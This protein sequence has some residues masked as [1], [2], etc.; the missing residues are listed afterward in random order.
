MMPF[1][2]REG[3]FW[4]KLINPTRMPEGEDWASVDWEVVEVIDNNG[5]GEEKFAVAFT[6]IAPWQWPRDCV[7]GAE[8]VRPA[9]LRS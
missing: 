6:G 1:P 7:F 4:A 5:E 8:V 9:C 2:A 3:W